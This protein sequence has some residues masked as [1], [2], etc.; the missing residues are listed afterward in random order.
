MFKCSEIPSNISGKWTQFLKLV[1]VLFDCYDYE[2]I[3]TPD[4]FYICCCV[5]HQSILLNNQLDAALSSHIYYSR[6]G[7]CTCFGVLSATIIRNTLKL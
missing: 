4:G 1:G 5:Q 2:R 6:P 3:H 7:Y